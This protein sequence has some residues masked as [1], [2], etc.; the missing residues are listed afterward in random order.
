MDGF[1]EDVATGVVEKKL[2][3]A[4]R[5]RAGCSE[6]LVILEEPEEPVQ[7]H[8]NDRL[9]PH[10]KRNCQNCKGGE[11]KP[12][13]YIG[14]WS[15]LRNELAILEL[16]V[17]CYQTAQFYAVR[18]DERGYESSKPRDPVFRGLVVEIRRATFDRSPRVLRCEPPGCRRTKIP[19]WPY[20]TRIELARVWGIPV[21]PKL[22]VGE[23]SA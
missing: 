5:P 6:E 1:L 11:I 9:V 15:W 18:I 20:H 2:R 4:G 14:A 23:E 13:W 10:F 17:T 3:I 12:F 8:W 7:M 21:K 16:S 22:Y 19:E